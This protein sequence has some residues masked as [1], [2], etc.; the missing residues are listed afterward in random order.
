MLVEMAMSDGGGRLMGGVTAQPFPISNGISKGCWRKSETLTFQKPFFGSALWVWLMIGAWEGFN[1]IYL[2]FFAMQRRLL[3]QCCCLCLPVGKELQLSSIIC[4]CHTCQGGCYLFWAAR[5]FFV[6]HP[7][8]WQW[9]YKW[10]IGLEE[11]RTW[12]L[13]IYVNTSFIG[14]RIYPDG[15]SHQSQGFWGFDSL[16]WQGLGFIKPHAPMTAW[17]VKAWLSQLHSFR[18]GWHS[19]PLISSLWPD[20]ALHRERFWTLCSLGCPIA[21][22]FG[23]MVGLKIHWS[24]NS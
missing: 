15:I 19:T 5:L 1:L 8:D 9:L 3:W 23:A 4:A 7:M 10:E 12:N 24:V 13:K 20:F 11:N 17:L 18:P 2:L 16:A 14:N 6:M 22:S 21:S